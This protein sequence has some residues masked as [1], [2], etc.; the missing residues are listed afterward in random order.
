MEKPL[1]APSAHRHGVDDGTIIHAF[2]N[3]IRTEDLDE[4]LTMIIGPDHA[5]NLYEIGVV[6][7]EDGPVVVHAMSARPKYLR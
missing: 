6:D 4:G 1:V 2:N 7:S 5:G 3:S